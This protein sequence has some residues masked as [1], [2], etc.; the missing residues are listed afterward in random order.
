[1][2][3][4]TAQRG[5]EIFVGAMEQEEKVVHLCR[6]EQAMRQ[7]ATIPSSLLE[8]IGLGDEFL[9]NVKEI[10]AWAKENP[11]AQYVYSLRDV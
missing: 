11:S 1:M 9:H 4:V 5:N 3:F 2:R 7:Q 6:A 8:C 10:V